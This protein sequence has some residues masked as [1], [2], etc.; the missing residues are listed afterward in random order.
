MVID[1]A[2]KFLTVGQ[3]P[4]AGG[5]SLASPTGLAGPLVDAEVVLRAQTWSG[6]GVWRNEGTA[7]ST[8][9]ATAVSAPWKMAGTER[10]AYFSGLPDEGA[11]C[12]DAAAID[13]TSGF[14]VAVDME[15]DWQPAAAQQ[16][17]AKP[18]TGDATTDDCYAVG[19]DSSGHPFI[20][21]YDTTDG[22][23]A[24]AFLTANGATADVTFA[25]GVARRQLVFEWLSTAQGYTARIYSGV[26]G[27][28]TLLSEIVNTTVGAQ[29][30]ETSTD[31]L[32]I[33]DPV[34]G[35]IYRVRLYDTLGGTLL[36][37]FYPDRDYA[38]GKTMTS[39]TGEVWSN[40]LVPESPAIGIRPGYFTIPDDPATD[41]NP[42]TTSLTVAALVTCTDFAGAA[43]F[44]P[45]VGK[46]SAAATGWFL[47]SYGVLGGLVAAAYEAGV[48]TA[49]D[50]SSATDGNRA[51]LVMRFDAAADDLEVAVDGT[52]SGTP[53][54]TAGV[55]DLGHGVGMNVGRLSVSDV[56]ARHLVHQVATW[57]RALTDAEIAALPYVM[58]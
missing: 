28:T 2:L 18:R 31:V 53:T 41:V 24:P 46:T 19:Y 44:T 16:I 12:P 50:A 56:I 42:T 5:L 17:L 36:R 11:T 9:D 49:T 54:S 43:A 40:V 29:T 21:H 4:V 33:G 7:G 6:S 13:L 1:G 10:A 39:A 51:L 23:V 57:D 27:A 14:V 32:K 20:E 48:P 3:G 26:P 55:G 30:I 37:D 35:A 22:H 15:T 47:A 58:R 45:Y 52:L 25:D 8:L 34:N 38:T